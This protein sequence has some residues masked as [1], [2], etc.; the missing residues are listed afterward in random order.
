MSQ[1]RL[2]SKALGSTCD[3]IKF[4]DLKAMPTA[5]VALDF[6]RHHLS[7]LVCPANFTNSE[8]KLPETLPG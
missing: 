6:D 3:E 5:H 2:L 4:T 8:V 7:P 1:G